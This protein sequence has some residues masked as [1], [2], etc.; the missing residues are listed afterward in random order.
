VALDEQKP[1]NGVIRPKR[2]KAWSVPSQL[3][4]YN[5]PVQ[6]MGIA[7][8]ISSSGPNRPAGPAST[9]GQVGHGRQ[10]WVDLPVE[11]TSYYTFR[12]PLIAVW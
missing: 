3:S 8:R 4:S 2:R 1:F 6:T 9:V 10:R 7:T 11:Y 5:S 12:S